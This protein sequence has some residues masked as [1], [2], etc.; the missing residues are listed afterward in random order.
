MNKIGDKTFVNG[1]DL[2]SLQVDG[3]MEEEKKELNDSVLGLETGCS[4]VA[5]FNPANKHKLKKMIA[6]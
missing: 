1:M 5:A 4:L 3:G 2:I 6:L